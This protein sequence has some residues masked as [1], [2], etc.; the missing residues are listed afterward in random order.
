M[1][2]V[3][4]ASFDFDVQLT[5]AES[6][7]AEAQTLG[8][9]GKGSFSGKPADMGMEMMAGGGDPAAMFIAMT[10]ALKEFSGDLT[11][12][13]TLPPKVLEEASKDLKGD[14]PET[15]TLQ[16]RLVDGVGYVNTD[17]LKPIL[18]AAG[19]KMPATMKG[20]IGLDIVEFLNQM[21]QEH[22]EMLADLAKNGEAFSVSGSEANA[23]FADPA[24]FASAIHIER[25]ENSEGAAIFTITLDFAKLAADP[26]FADMIKAQAEKQGETITDEELQKGLDV[27][28]NAGDAI[29][30]TA[31][32]MIDLETGYLRSI[33]LNLDVDGSKFPQ[34]TA[35]S[36]S[37]MDEGKVSMSA[38]VNIS[39][40]NNAPDIT[41]PEESMV[42]P[43]EFLIGMM[44]SM[45]GSAGGAKPDAT[46]E[47]TP[48]ATPGS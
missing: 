29:Q 23:M 9:T 31:T 35:N 2:D 7:D 34:D 19:Q 36:T 33:T 17:T 6:T 11:L 46:S 14:L 15:I 10:D 4:S 12:N 26:A 8:L 16:V 45:G 32:E 43:P 42:L 48:E 38:T 47:A 41:E 30:F 27:I 13:L 40:V 20:W 3:S 44:D 39:D 37:G 18:E 1:K 28:A 25:N 22:P 5:V 21:I 24:A